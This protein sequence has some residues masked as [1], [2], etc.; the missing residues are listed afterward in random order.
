MF[1]RYYSRLYLCLSDCGCFWGQ[2]VGQRDCVHDFSGLVP[3]LLLLPWVV[4][5]I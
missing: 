2:G 5:H 4:D 3:S 1:F